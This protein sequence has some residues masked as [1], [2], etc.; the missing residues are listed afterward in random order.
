MVYMIQTNKEIGLKP[1][2]DG[3]GHLNISAKL[4]L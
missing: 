4:K 2:P 1:F 3:V